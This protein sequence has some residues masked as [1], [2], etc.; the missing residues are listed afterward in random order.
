[1]SGD[2]EERHWEHRKGDQYRAAAGQFVGNPESGYSCE[3]QIASQAH[4][5]LGYAISGGFDMVECDDFNVVAIRDGKVAAILWMT[6]IIDEE[7]EV[8]RA[9]ADRLGIEASS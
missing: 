6:E 8:L 9:M 3:Y 5:N 7:P 1:M 2:T 4:P